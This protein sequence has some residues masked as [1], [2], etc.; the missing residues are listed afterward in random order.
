MCKSQEIGARIKESRK[1]MK[2]SQTDLADA[3]NKSLRTIQKYES[4]EIELNIATINDIAKVLKTSPA[5]LLGYYSTSNIEVT[6]VA[7]LINFLFQLDDKQEVHFDLDIKKPKEDGKWSCSIVFDGQ[8]KEHK[9]N[10]SIC[11]ILEDYENHR[12]LLETD[13]ISKKSYTEW[14]EK[15]LAY[16]SDSLL[17]DKSDNHEE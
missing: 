13:W 11:L 16:Y 15:K 10:S 1:L 4:G 5:H 3:L 17:T 9:Y 8:D 2:L 7:D 14:Q 6:C 12:D